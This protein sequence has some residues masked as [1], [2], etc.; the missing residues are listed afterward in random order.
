M[1]RELSRQI[2][3]GEKNIQTPIFIKIR[4][5]GAEL[6][7]ADGQTDMTNLTVTFRKFARAPKNERRRDNFRFN[8]G[9]TSNTVLT[10]ITMLLCF[11][12]A[13]CTSNAY[14]NTAYRSV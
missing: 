1:K 8:V 10:W 14:W 2:F 11:H 7:H 3:G 5:V 6:F 12:V 13:L 4:S 9:A